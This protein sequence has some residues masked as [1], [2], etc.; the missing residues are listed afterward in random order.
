MTFSLIVTNYVRA[1]CEDE[2]MALVTPVLDAMRHEPT[3][4]NTVLHRASDNAA[5][6]MLYE[7]WSDRHEFFDVQ[8]RRDYRQTYERRLPELLLSPRKMQIFEPLRGDFRFGS[9]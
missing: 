3:F 8:M 9:V 6:F 1:G 2:Y 7:T 4:I 5:S